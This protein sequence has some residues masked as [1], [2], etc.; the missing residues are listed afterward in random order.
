[1]LSR[2]GW[3]ALVA[4]AL[5][6]LLD[7][8]RLALVE[9]DAARIAGALPLIEPPITAVQRARLAA[10]AE[11]FRAIALDPDRA[12]HER[13]G[14][15]E[16]LW[17]CRRIGE[18]AG[19]PES[20]ATDLDDL[21]DAAAE[22]GLPAQ[23]ALLVDA[24][25]CYAADGA[26]HADLQAD[27]EQ[28]AVALG[29]QLDPENGWFELAAA[30]SAAASGRMEE[31]RDLVQRASRAPRI[32][33]Y[34][35]ERSAAAYQLLRARGVP[36]LDARVLLLGD[37]FNGF[38]VQ[39]G[40]LLDAAAE[41][42]A[43]AARGPAAGA[44]GSAWMDDYAALS[45]AG[46]KVLDSALLHEDA[47]RALAAADRYAAELRPAEL[48]AAEAG[49][50]TRRGGVADVLQAAGFSSA[51]AL[52]REVAEIRANLERDLE[53]QLSARVRRQGRRP[54]SAERVLLNS[55]AHGILLGF[56]GVAL[57]AWA[58]LRALGRGSSPQPAPG[59]PAP[60][61]L[62]PWVLAAAV[63]PFLVWHL[64]QRGLWPF[65]AAG[66]DWYRQL[67]AP[68]TA[69]LLLPL[70]A[71]PFA[72]LPLLAH[73]GTRG[74]IPLARGLA[75][76]FGGYALVLAVVYAASTPAIVRQRDACSR[77]LDSDLID[78]LWRVDR[79]R[80]PEQNPGS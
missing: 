67:G 51:V 45:A 14:A 27:I 66:G 24:A 58:S 41:A 63:P 42:L 38:E 76:F 6:F 77:A 31:A 75:L 21:F 74:R 46:R 25:R 52:A 35:R 57:L 60:L 26:I 28:R 40:A 55:A 10:S 32:D 54:P 62:G 50:G 36:D 13:L 1:M 80:W 70:A 44:A 30:A 37:V 56:A 73:R 20:R 7:R 59:A 3:L 29:L 64:G 8:E 33:G 72:A 71:L 19:G 15:S 53:R 22:T 34:P 47:R 9:E 2:I 23:V 61:A 4:L 18:A 12:P 65:D 17:Q 49:R 79:P 78:D 16:L 11:Q 43:L 39:S 68:T 69:L 5:P 48:R